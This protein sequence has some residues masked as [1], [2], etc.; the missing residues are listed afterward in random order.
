MT[1]D[2]FISHLVELR[3]RL[4]RSL[5]SVGIVFA[6]LCI[7]PG[8]G[9]IYDVLALPLTKELPEGTRM[10]AT[11]V[12]TP[13]LVPVK[14]TAMVA[15]MLA[16]P[17]V[18][19]QIWAFVAPGLYAHEKRL[20]LP[21]VLSSTL[22]FVAGVAFCYFIVF[23]QVFR[24]IAGFAP[25][26]ITPAPDIEQYLSFVLT[27]F[28][29]F[30][31]AF[32]VPVALIVLVRMGVVSVERLRE[33]R[34]Y[35]VVGASVAAAIITPPDVVSMLALLLPMW[36][37]YELGIVIAVLTV[38]KAAKGGADYGDLSEVEKKGD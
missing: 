9:A 22:L 1:E 17:Y 8:P 38:R 23:G 37:L 27:M 6:L 11:S 14:V 2:T 24:F 12:I 32:E 20:V 5:G 28:I 26:S 10:I 31:L 16:L 19:Y 25:A 36:L 34:G 4:L 18:L 30:G 15:F 29:A 33:Y 13:F 7:Y 21:L 3:D 35:F